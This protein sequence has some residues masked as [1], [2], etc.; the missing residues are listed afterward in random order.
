[1]HKNAKTNQANVIMIQCF[2]SFMCCMCAL[3][4]TNFHA[5]ITL[6]ADININVE[7]AYNLKI[8]VVRPFELV[9]SYDKRSAMVSGLPC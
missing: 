6:I 1:M 9:I 4:K 5:E 8:V 3:T 2:A 7:M